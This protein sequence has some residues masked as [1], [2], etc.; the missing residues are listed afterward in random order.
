MAKE[1]VLK[2][3][4]Q[5]EESPESHDD[6]A[7][8]ILGVFDMLSVLNGFKPGLFTIS[9]Q[10]AGRSTWWELSKTESDKYIVPAL[11]KYIEDKLKE[12]EDLL[13]SEKTQ[14]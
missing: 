12:A 13:K 5:L 2:V 9:V 6:L 1:R 10:K 3:L 8:S 11:D 7:F 14:D 4:K